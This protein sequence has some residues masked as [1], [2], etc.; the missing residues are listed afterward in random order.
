M[1][2]LAHTHCAREHNSDDGNAIGVLLV[3]PLTHE[4]HAGDDEQNDGPR[5]VEQAEDGRDEAK[6]EEVRHHE[7]EGDDD[8]VDGVLVVAAV[9]VIDAESAEEQVEEA[10]DDARLTLGGR[11]G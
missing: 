8:L 7:H 1:K 11:V 2:L 10:S 6:I 9:E 3:D 5:V 4:G